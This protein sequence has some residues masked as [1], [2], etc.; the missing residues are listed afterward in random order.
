MIEKAPKTDYEMSYDDAFLYC[1]ML[2]YNGHKDWRL[3]TEYEYIRELQW[4]WFEGRG[5]SE[6]HWLVQP[7]RTNV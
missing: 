3:P 6:F 2:E 1:L 7:V 5:D 4:C